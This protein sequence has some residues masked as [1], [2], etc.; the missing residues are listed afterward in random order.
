MYGGYKSFNFKYM[1]KNGNGA[2]LGLKNNNLGQSLMRE[3]RF[4]SIR[5]SFKMYQKKPGVIIRKV[6]RERRGRNK[7][8]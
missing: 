7:K 3:K 4:M 2:I 8:K 6:E 1:L 5:L